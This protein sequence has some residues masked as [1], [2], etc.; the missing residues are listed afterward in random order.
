MT[1]G[2]DCLVVTKEQRYA[3]SLIDFG[4]SIESNDC[5]VTGSRALY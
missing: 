5:G 2:I 4:R 1:L 3:T